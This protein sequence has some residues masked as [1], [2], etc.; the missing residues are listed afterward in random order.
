VA[1]DVVEA[2][3]VVLTVLNE[4]ELVFCDIEFEVIARLVEA[5]LVCDEHPFA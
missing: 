1:A 3:D 4:D 2:V 5:G